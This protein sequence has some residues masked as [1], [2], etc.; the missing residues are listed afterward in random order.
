ML[1]L[2]EMYNN[3]A[4][5]VADYQFVAGFQVVCCL[6]MMA[7]D[8]ASKNSINVMIQKKQRSHISNVCLTQKWIG[9]HY[10]P[11]DTICTACMK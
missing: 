10:Q 1:N 6:C 8:I 5:I 7:Y 3:L 11:N 4:E 9:Y 2:H